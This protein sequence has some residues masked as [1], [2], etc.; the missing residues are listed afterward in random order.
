[1]NV[2]DKIKNFEMAFQQLNRKLAGIS[3]TLELIC[4]GGYVMNIY[5]Y[6][7]TKD[8]DAFFENNEEVAQLIEE[9]GNE[10]NINNPDELWLNNSLSSLN[11]K[12]SEEHCE[13]QYEFSNLTVRHVS[14][15]YLMGMKLSSL[16]EQDLLDVKRILQDHDEMQPFALFSEFK[17]M[18]FNIDISDLLIGFEEARGMDW[19]EAFY[20]ANQNELKAYY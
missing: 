19:L 18:G 14:L 2:S 8:I 11:K 6:R 9:V 10:L 5:G 7:G 17:G 15:I 16:R 1:M 12:P 13:I 3:R 4:A 20:K